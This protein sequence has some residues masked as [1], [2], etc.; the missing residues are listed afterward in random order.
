MNTPVVRLSCATVAVAPA[1]TPA[2]M[3]TAAHPGSNNG[4]NEIKI[5]FLPTFI[6]LSYS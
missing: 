4:I 2:P 3:T 1:A 6:L 5:N